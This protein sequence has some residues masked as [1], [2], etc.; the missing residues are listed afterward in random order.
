MAEPTGGGS[1]RSE[2]TQPMSAFTE[3]S[4]SSFGRDRAELQRMTV[5]QL[6]EILKERRQPI[7]KK[8]KAQM[9]EAKP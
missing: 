3:A 6:R 2:I 5:L 8:N 1:A 7:G 9:I 4:V